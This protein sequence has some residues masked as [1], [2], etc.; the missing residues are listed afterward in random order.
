MTMH[1][2]ATIDVTKAPQ[3]DYFR[4]GFEVVNADGEYIEFVAVADP[5]NGWNVITTCPEETMK[6]I[7]AIMRKRAGFRD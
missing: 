2:T 1:L 3:I 5:K 7:C 4:L 6:E